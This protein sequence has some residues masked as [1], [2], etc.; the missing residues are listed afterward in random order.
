MTSTVNQLQAQEN[1]WDG[2]LILAAIFA[3]L[4]SR[5]KELKHRSLT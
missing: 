3:H 4:E 2:K 5:G 1:L